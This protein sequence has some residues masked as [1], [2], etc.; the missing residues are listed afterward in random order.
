MPD[1]YVARE[2][3]HP[4]GDQPSGAETELVEERSCDL[5][6]IVVMIVIIVVMI[7]IIMVMIVIV[8]MVVIIEVMVIIAVLLVGSR[9]LWLDHDAR[10]GISTER[11]HFWREPVGLLCSRASGGR[12]IRVVGHNS[13]RDHQ[14]RESHLDIRGRGGQADVKTPGTIETGHLPTRPW[15]FSDIGDRSRLPV[16]IEHLKGDVLLGVWIG[17]RA[18]HP[19][20]EIDTRFRD[21][22]IAR[23]GADADACLDLPR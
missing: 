11:Q 15:Y 21:G 13:R 8:V 23:P 3:S 22:G 17:K 1:W 9:A 14:R 19:L 4:N 7:V 12:P 20:G 10:D 16:F 18:G 2:R 5:I 6:V